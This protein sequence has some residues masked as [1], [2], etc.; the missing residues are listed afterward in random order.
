MYI[1]PNLKPLFANLKRLKIGKYLSSTEFKL[2]ALEHDFED[3]WFECLNSVYRR[4][5]VIVIGSKSTIDEE[6]ALMIFLSQCYVRNDNSFDDVIYIILLNFAKWNTTRLDY[7]SVISNLKKIGF[8]KEYILGFIKEFRRNQEKKPFKIETVSNN[9]SNEPPLISVNSNKIFVVHGRDDKSRLELCN[10]LKD[11]LKLEPIVLQEMPNDSIE[12]IIAKFERLANECSAAIILFT[13]D[14]D[15]GENKRARQNVILEL[16]YFLGKFHDK[17]NRR[18]IILKKGHPEIPSDISGVL[19]LEY[20][21]AVKESYYDLKKQF[22]HW[23]Y[24]LS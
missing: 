8:S 23:G 1:E 21:K 6:T 3:F 18:I 14:D 4:S 20:N 17:A 15:A 12:T 10:L 19:Y 9:I 24:P 11:D 13:P 16:G 5:N 7:T 22:D 2:C